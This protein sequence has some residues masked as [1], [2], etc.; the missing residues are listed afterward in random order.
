MRKHEIENWVLRVVDQVKAGQPNEDSRVE[1]KTDWLK[2]DKAAWQ[3]AGHANAARGDLILWLI[4]VDEKGQTVVGANH[5]ELSSWYP[6]VK[7]K[8]DQGIAPILI[9]DLNVPVEDK[10]V[11]AL[12]FETDRAPFVIKNPEGGQ[13]TYAVPLRRGNKTLCADRSDLLRLLSPIQKLPEV[14]FLGC[15]LV[16]E[17]SKSYSSRLGTVNY[18]SPW[19]LN[20]FLDLYIFPNGN[21]KVVFPWHRCKCLVELPTIIPPLELK[22]SHFKPPS[23]STV[24]ASSSIKV[25]DSEVIVTDPGKLTLLASKS[26]SE[27]YASSR[28]NIE[29]NLSLGVI[30]ADSPVLIRTSTSYPGFSEGEYFTSDI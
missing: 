29:I 28:E 30:A 5:I 21:D 22:L 9:I 6:A 3:I 23:W 4:G 8:F 17:P 16:I 24:S 18:G 10:T 26:L 25:S 13:I 14:E 19:K 11:V 20:V 15:K 27:K 7:S 1:L 12:L 2:P